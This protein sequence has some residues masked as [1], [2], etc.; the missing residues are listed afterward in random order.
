M[1]I[2]PGEDFPTVPRHVQAILRHRVFGD[3]LFYLIVFVELNSPET[4]EDI[5]ISDD[6]NAAI[7]H[8]DVNVEANNSFGCIIN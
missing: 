6:N 8:N 7:Y 1:I 4:V 5:Y 3:I 2:R